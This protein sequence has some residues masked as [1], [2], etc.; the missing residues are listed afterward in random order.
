MADCIDDEYM[1][2]QVRPKR[3]TCPEKIKVIKTN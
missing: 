3:E 1:V 2:L